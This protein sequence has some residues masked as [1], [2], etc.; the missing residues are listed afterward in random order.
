MNQYKHFLNFGG[1]VNSVAYEIYL[2]ELGIEHESVF[3]DH[4]ADNPKTY[5]YVEYFNT[6]LIKRGLKP[7]TIIDGKVKEKSMEK[8]LNLMEYC[9]YKKT[10]PQR[11]LRWC[12]EKFK[13]IPCNEYINSK[14]EEGEQ[15]Y[16]HLGIASDEEHRARVPQNPAPY[17]RNK[18][19]KFLFVED[20]ITR[21]D[22]IEM[23]EKAEFEV[24]PKSGCYICPF[25]PNKELRKLYLEEPCLYE[26]AKNLEI[27]VNKRRELEGKGFTG[28][29]D[30][31]ISTIVQEG[32]IYLDIN[33]DGEFEWINDRKPCNCNL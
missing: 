11:L 17:L 25:Q 2:N 32:Q 21:A 23:I 28:I 5:E 7:V 10:V 1:G 22:N 15:V 3:C 27:T 13:I 6:E 16:Y 26:K 29:K 4:G 19:F 33:D 12:T 18:I 8:A 24:P 20:G 14:I 9:E 31:P 30:K